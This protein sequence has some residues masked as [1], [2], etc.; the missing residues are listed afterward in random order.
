MISEFEAEKISNE[1]VE[2]LVISAAV[3]KFSSATEIDHPSFRDA[4]RLLLDV[5]PLTPNIQVE[6][7]LIEGLKILK[8][9]LSK[10]K[11]F[12]R[13]LPSDFRGDSKIKIRSLNSV[14]NLLKQSEI[15]E[16]ILSNPEEILQVANKLGLSN[17][18]QQMEVQMILANL[19]FTSGNTIF[20]LQLLMDLISK[21]Y[22]PCWK[23]CAEVS[24]AERSDIDPSMKKQLLLHCIANCPATDLERFVLF[25]KKSCFEEI[26][27]PTDLTISSVKLEEIALANLNASS[28][29]SSEIDN[30]SVPLISKNLWNNRSKLVYSRSKFAVSNVL[31]CRFDSVFDDISISIV[32]VLWKKDL[33]RV[34]SFLF[35]I[36]NQSFALKYLLKFT[37]NNESFVS[38]ENFKKLKFIE[39][40]FRFSCI[41]ILSRSCSKLDL[42]GIFR[43]LLVMYYFI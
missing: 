21:D 32:E 16:K 37:L 12:Q 34:E 23:I 20:L 30:F 26:V 1:V 41:T 3:L 14:L 11:V 19:A 9:L 15:A 8:E 33:L 25:W 18:E 28:W 22:K 5:L 36:S 7:N 42:I 29:T 13:V 24:M 10:W 17:F 40:C 39:L 38:A 4:E 27:R 6:L 2:N 35:A 31:S 43:I